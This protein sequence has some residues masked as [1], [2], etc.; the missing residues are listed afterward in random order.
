MLTLYTTPV[1]YLPSIS[2]GSGGKSDAQVLR[3]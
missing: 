1:L 2:F 3:I